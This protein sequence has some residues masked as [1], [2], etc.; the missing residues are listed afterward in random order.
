MR[1]EGISIELLG[2]TISGDTEILG[3]GESLETDEI[4][5]LSRVKLGSSESSLLDSLS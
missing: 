4:L 5:I 2:V 3:R 1:G